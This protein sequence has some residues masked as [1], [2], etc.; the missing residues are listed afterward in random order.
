[1]PRRPRT[2]AALVGIALL[3]ATTV[4]WGQP[5]GPNRPETRR[6]IDVLQDLQAQGLKLLFSSEIVRAD[7]RVLAARPVAGGVSLR[8]V[9]D[10]VL[11]PHGLIARDGPGGTVLVVKNPRA[12]IAGG[13]RAPA[14]AAHVTGADSVAVPEARVEPPRFE[15]TIDV[16]GSEPRTATGG[17]PPFTVRPLDARGLAGG[18]ENVFRTLQTLPGV[19]GTDEL[20]SRI[21]VRGGTPDQNL[22]M[23]DGVEIH[24]PFRLVVA[25]EDLA[26]IGLASTFNADTIESVDLFPAAFDVRYGDRLSSLLVV[27]N[28]EGSETEALQGSSS[29][30]LSDANVVLE[31]ALPA[32]AAGSWLLS[33]RRTFLGVAAKRLVG[34]TLPSFQDVHTRVSWRPGPQQRIGV[35]GQVG[36]ERTQ[37]GTAV[38][39]AG[40]TTRTRNRLLAFT[41]ESGLG[42]RASTR[43]VASYSLF[44]DALNAYERS[45]DNSL[46]ANTADSIAGGGLLQFQLSRQ[47]EVRDLALRQELVLTP[48]PTHWLDLGAEAHALDTRWAWRIAGDRSPQQAN[49]SSVRLGAALPDVLDSSRDSARYGAWV[50]D[51]WRVGRR[52][53]LQPGL[54]VDRSSLTRRG[55][56]SPRL[57]GTLGLGPTWR[58]NGAVRWHAQSPGYEKMLQSDY[59]IDLSAKPAESL[60]SERALHVVAG[61]ERS[62]GGGLSARVDGYYKRSRDLL[63]GRLETEPE[64]AARVA[65]YDVPAPLLSAVPLDAQ[66]TTAPSNAASGRA[67]GIEAQVAL[68]GSRSAVPLTGWA[69]YSFAKAQQ[70]AYGVTYPADYDRR[71]AVSV[72]GNLRLGP[73]VDLTA[74]G[75]WAT[76]LPRTPVRGVRLALVADAGDADG[77]GLREE[78]V[79]QRDAQG[80]VVFQPDFGGVAQLNSARLPRFGRLDA[81]LTYRPS[82]SGERWAFYLDALNAL[83][84][85]NV[86]QIDSALTLTPTSDRPGIVEVIQDHGLGFFPSV[87][88]RFWF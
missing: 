35:I 65:A 71:H 80:H 81:L 74:T 33:A 76:G 87:G 45:L 86:T 51:R 79:P 50:Q 17:P 23:M 14:P 18:Y 8:R 63:V 55:S 59:F 62:F 26:A 21:A 82:W 24:N 11:A 10:E 72:S 41:V 31:G 48:S 64:R 88:I 75:R 3:C 12:R 54:R 53:T 4:A 83:N 43:T 60:V 61:L 32:G 52:L 66:I 6:L 56:L 9:L 27:K 49:G 16:T 46:G 39:D 69:T 73:R 84:T 22:T 37:P 67:Y 57:S 85:K 25:L 78:R 30:S 15:E 29:L 44:A 7:M 38:A 77:D 58:L 19:A 42:P 1:M 28:R 5:A 47:I 20:G 36:T 34:T 68:A 40:N 70:S 2:I 13:A